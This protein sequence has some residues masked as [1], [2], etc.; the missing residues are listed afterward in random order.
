MALADR[1]K[2]ARRRKEWSERVLARESGVPYTT[3]WRLEN[4]RTAEPTVGVLHKL[5]D[6]LGTSIDYLVGS[7]QSMEADSNLLE[8][9]EIERAYEFARS[10]PGFQFGTRVRGELSIEATRFIVELYQKA[11]GKKLL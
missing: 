2:A 6:A 11:A 1:L 8:V 10:D 7:A 5:A 4:G 3:I 9:D